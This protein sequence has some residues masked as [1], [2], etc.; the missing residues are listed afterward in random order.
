[1]EKPLDKFKYEIIIKSNYRRKNYLVCV[2][3][4]IIQ[5][6]LQVSC[7]CFDLP[8]ISVQLQSQHKK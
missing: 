1:M 3:A 5:K 4:I 7:F 8:L 2:F 6:S